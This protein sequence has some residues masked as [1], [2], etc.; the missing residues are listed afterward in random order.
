MLGRSG[1]AQIVDRC[2]RLAT[3][4]A[5]HLR[6]VPGAQILNDVVLNQVLV[7]FVAGTGENRTPAV[8]AAVQ[9]AGVC[10]CGGTTWEGQPAMRISISNWRTTEP[11]IDKSA[12]SIA[13]AMTLSYK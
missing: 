7:R 6:V 1:L 3:R 13:E 2:C 10:W 11:D 9:D 4:M 5:D 8:I 12:V